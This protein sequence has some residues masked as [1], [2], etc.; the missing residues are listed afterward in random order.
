MCSFMKNIFNGLS[1][2]AV[3]FLLSMPTYAGEPSADTEANPAALNV[4]ILLYHR[5]G[6]IVADGMTITT[7]VFE[8]HLKYLKEN[9]YRVIP[10]RQ[11][12]DYYLKKGPKPLPKSVVIVV[13][14]GHESVYKYMLPVVMEY[15]V[16]VTLFLYPSA[17]SNASYAMTWGQLRELKKTG[18]FDFQGHTYWHPNFKK[19]EKRMS[20]FEYEKS[21]DLQL[22]KSRTK[23]E[24]ELGVQIDML[25]WPFG[26]YNDWLVG[27]AKE[28]GYAATFSIEA[29]HSTEGDA[30]MKMPRYL[31]TNSDKG[32]VFERIVKGKAERRNPVY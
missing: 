9:G 5:F 12:A 8:A 27:K 25:A 22:K 10:L 23:L 24:Q 1:L 28:A 11:L 6:P 3:I 31:L 19:D 15:R 14:D 7:P 26:I 32:K 20:R 4:P 30:I 16:P 29:R 21:V 2:L 13:D 18:L 17:I